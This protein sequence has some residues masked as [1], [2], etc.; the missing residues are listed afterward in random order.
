MSREEE[1]FCQLPKG[2]VCDLPK[3]ITII[4]EHILVIQQDQAEMKM[5]LMELDTK[6]YGNG[7]STGL[8]TRVDRVEQRHEWEDKS[9]RKASQWVI[10]VS[11]G[12]VVAIVATLLAWYF[13]GQ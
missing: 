8:C 11:G 13:K 3:D 9:G 4:K 7:G 2:S 12:I 10:N 5:S 1:R 6:L